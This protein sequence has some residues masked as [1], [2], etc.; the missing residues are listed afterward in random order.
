MHQ[1]NHVKN[2]NDQTFNS[3]QPYNLIPADHPSN[4]KRGGVY[5]YIFIIMNHLL[6]HLLKIITS[7]NVYY[8][9]SLLTIKKVTLHS[10]IN[11]LPKSTGV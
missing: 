6:F 5:M 7:M 9:K 1:K 11:P 4:N 8:V 10:Y 3:Q 2:N